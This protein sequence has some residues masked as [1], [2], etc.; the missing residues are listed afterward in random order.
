MVKATS[1]NQE[2]ETQTGSSPE[3]EAGGAKSN[4]EFLN[5][6]KDFLQGLSSIVESGDSSEISEFIEGE[7]TEATKEGKNKAPAGTGAK[8]ATVTNVKK[9]DAALPS[10]EIMQIQVSTKIEKEIRVLE[11]EAAKLMSANGANFSPHKL[12]SVIAQIRSL[13]EILAGLVYSTAEAIKSLWI[14][15]IKNVG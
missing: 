2:K 4:T 3:I 9:K 5:S 6:S 15:Y 7:V 1:N 14:K 10:I 11:R 12:N 13:R 8:A